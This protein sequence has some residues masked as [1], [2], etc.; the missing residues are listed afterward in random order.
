[1]SKGR[2]VAITVALILIYSAAAQTDSDLISGAAY[3][4]GGIDKFSR[5]RYQPFIV[6]YSSILSM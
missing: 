4:L 5:P 2:F 1:M 6:G 3:K